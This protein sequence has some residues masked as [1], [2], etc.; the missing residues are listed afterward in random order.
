MSNS[1]NSSNPPGSNPPGGSPAD[2]NGPH[3]YLAANSSSGGP[4]TYGFSVSSDGQLTP[5]SGFPLSYSIWGVAS[6]NY[7][8]ATNA[9]GVHIDTY[10]I[11]SDGSLT[12]VQSFDDTKASANACAQCQPGMPQL[13]DPTGTK[14]YISAGYLDG[15][16]W[17]STL[18]TFSIDPATG[19]ISYVSTDMPIE[20]RDWAQ[21][22]GS[23]S[24]NAAYL[25]GTNETTFTNNVVLASQTSNGSLSSSPTEPA[26]HGLSSSSVDSMVI[27]TDS[28]SHLVAAIQASNA[29]GDPGAPIQLASFTI[30]SDGSLT[31]TN[32]SEQMPQ[33][34]SLNGSVSPDGT[35]IAM[36]GAKSGIQL[37]NFNGADPITALGGMLA[38]DQITSLSWDK[39]HHLYALSS[40]HMLYVFNV[41]SAGATPAPG[42]PH[43][44][45]NAFNLL[46]QP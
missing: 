44:L 21:V 46:V 31:T 30:N 8:F 5:I 10:K 23:F 34:P 2:S 42:S 36:V 6:G 3:I 28:T 37:Y 11:S 39:Q 29:N 9:D 27:G 17:T 22:Y 13:A 25:Y 4:S 43:S 35:L 15:G 32:S 41:T 26:L 18:Q 33:A 45:P 40:S 24:G 7:L 12:K 20:G 1:L 38:T 14:L 16:D 19:A